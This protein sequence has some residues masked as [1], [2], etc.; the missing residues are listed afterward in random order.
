MNQNK[1]K[2]CRLIGVIYFW[3]RVGKNAQNTVLNQST[4]TQTKPIIII[5][6]KMK[7]SSMTPG[8]KSK[9]FINDRMMALSTPKPNEFLLGPQPEVPPDVSQICQS[10]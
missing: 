8:S 7:I 9:S 4:N 3:Y 6:K 1:K 5:Q 10:Q 2:T